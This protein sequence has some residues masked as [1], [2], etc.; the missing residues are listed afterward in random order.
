MA[1]GRLSQSVKSMAGLL[2]LAGVVGERLCPVILARRTGLSTFGGTR[3]RTILLAAACGIAA[4]ACSAGFSADPR[5][6][7][8]VARLRET[9]SGFGTIEAHYHAV[10]KAVDPGQTYEFESDHEWILDGDRRLL[11]GRSGQVGD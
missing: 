7:E 1:P 4:S 11:S 9:L 6:K 8:P 3:I 2:A 5:P 10:S